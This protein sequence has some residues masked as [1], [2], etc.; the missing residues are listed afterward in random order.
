MYRNLVWEEVLEKYGNF[1]KPYFFP[2]I[3]AAFR[4]LYQTNDLVAR[5]KDVLDIK[6]CAKL[7]Y[8]YP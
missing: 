2:P 8:I 4:Y 1:L 5:T 7:R 6:F 3:I